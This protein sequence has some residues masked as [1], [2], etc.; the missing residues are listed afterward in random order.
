MS[1]ASIG[2]V[3]YTHCRVIHFPHLPVSDPK[4]LW[5]TDDD[6]DGV[7]SGEGKQE[8]EMY[9]RFMLRPYKR[10]N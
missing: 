6:E 2:W 4:C 3:T 5:V 10:G 7:I 8:G 9:I 1:S